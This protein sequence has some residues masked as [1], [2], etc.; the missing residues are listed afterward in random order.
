M[1]DQ[2]LPNL[3]PAAGAATSPEA[4]FPS[5]ASIRYAQTPFPSEASAC[6][7]LRSDS[8]PPPQSIAARLAFRPACQYDSEENRHFIRA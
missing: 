2:R 8:A 3:Q 5:R 1:S 6:L 7:L 4:S